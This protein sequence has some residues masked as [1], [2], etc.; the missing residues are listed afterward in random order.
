V[1]YDLT[2]RAVL[3]RRAV[4]LPAEDPRRESGGGGSHPIALDQH[5]VYY[6]TPDGDL[7]WTVPDGETERVRP[8]G[9]LAVARGK[10]VWQVDP[11]TIRMLQPFFSVSF[12]R[13]G[14][15]AEISA[16]GTRVLTHT[17]GTGQGGSFGTVH[18]YD[19]RSGESLWTGLT[20]R[21]VPIAATLG[22]ETEVSYL[23]EP[24]AERPHNDDFVRQSASSPYELRTCDH[25]AHQCRSVTQL[26]RVETTPVLAR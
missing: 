22:P 2:A 19:T 23:V 26:P 7:A 24:R 20:R 11:T 14:T 25:E 13:P 16:D 17:F 6:A 21:D 10:R 18:L 3:A 8:D 4:P 5:K 9:L 15:G 1:V 12:D